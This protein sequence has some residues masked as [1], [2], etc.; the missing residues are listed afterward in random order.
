MAFWDAQG[1]LILG[2]LDCRAVMNT[3]HCWTTLWQLKEAICMTHPVLITQEVNCVSPHT[4]CVTTLLVQFHL[5]CLAHLSYGLDVEPRLPALQ[6][7]EEALCRKTL[8]AWWVKAKVCQWMQRWKPISFFT[9]I[10]SWYVAGTD[11][12][13]CLTIILKNSIVDH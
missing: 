8:L 12:S 9:E 5:E 1:I 10:N 4:V 6:I 7:S 13:V 2:F 11:V 3:D